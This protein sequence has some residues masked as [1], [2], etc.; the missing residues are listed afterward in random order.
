LPTPA[1][2]ADQVV[3]TRN[4]AGANLGELTITRHGD[5]WGRFAGSAWLNTESLRSFR[6]GLLRI[7]RLFGTDGLLTPGG[8]EQGQNGGLIVAVSD[9]V[10]VSVRGFRA[11][12]RPRIP[13]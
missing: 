2:L 8:C 9:M 13:G 1:D 6:R 4:T 12:Q 10:N 7:A 5:A 3:L 11:Y